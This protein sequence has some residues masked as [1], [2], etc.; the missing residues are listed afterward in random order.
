MAQ[1]Y[2]FTVEYPGVETK[3]SDKLYIIPQNYIT[4]FFFRYG[5]F[6]NND[7]S[8]IK[9]S[10]LDFR[11]AQN[12][13][14]KSK[15]EIDISIND[16]AFPE[17]ENFYLGRTFL[18][19]GYLYL[20]SKEDKNKFWE[21]K[22]S[23]NG[24][25]T[26]VVWGQE[27]DKDIKEVEA[28]GV[29]PCKI[30]VKPAEYY[31]A[32]SRTR[33]DKKYFRQLLSDENKL[34]ERAQL[35]NCNG[36][37]RTTV[38]SNSEVVN[39]NE[40]TFGYHKGRNYEKY[41]QDIQQAFA[42]C[43]NLD[44]P[45]PD[46][47]IDVYFDDMFIT[48]RDP[49]GCAEDIFEVLDEKTLHLKA[50]TASLPIGKSPESIKQDVKKREEEYED[51]NDNNDKNSRK[52]LTHVAIPTGIS[53]IFI[54]ALSVYQFVYGNT[55]NEKK[56]G[57]NVNKKMLE[58]ILAV[59]ERKNLREEIIN[60]R[61]DFVEFLD[62]YEYIR[63]FKDF[64][65]GNICNIVEG[66]LYCVKH[67]NLLAERFTN[68]DDHLFLRTEKFSKSSNIDNKR[69]RIRKF[70]E[71][72]Y[73]AEANFST[74]VVGI[75][76]LL[77]TLINLDDENLKNAIYATDLINKLA[78]LFDT[79]LDLYIKKPPLVNQKVS[80]L[81]RFIKSKIVDGE[82]FVKM[83]PNTI[84]NILKKY[85]I[86]ASEIDLGW[87]ESKNSYE[88][89]VQ[90]KRMSFVEEEIIGKKGKKY[91]IRR[92]KTDVEI[93]R[94][95][96]NLKNV[97]K[98][99]SNPYF[100]RALMKLSLLNLTVA[101]HQLDQDRSQNNMVN[102]AG[103]TADFA[104]ACTKSI[105]IQMGII[106]KSAKDIG[107]IGRFVK[108]INNFSS[109]A[110]SFLTAVYCGMESRDAFKV[111]D[112]D[113]GVAFAASGAFF[114][115][116][117]ILS[118]FTIPWGVGL[119]IGIFAIGSYI[120]ANY[121]RDDDFEN[122]FNNSWFRKLDGDKYEIFYKRIGEESWQYVSRIYSC[123]NLLMPDNDR[124][125]PWKEDI[126]KCFQDFLN[127]FNINNIE[128]RGTIY[129]VPNILIDFDVID[130]A[131]G[132]KVPP[133]YNNSKYADEIIIKTQFDFDRILSDPNQLEYQMYV[134]DKNYKPLKVEDFPKGSIRSNTVFVADDKK[135]LKTTIYIP[136]WL[137]ERHIE[138]NQLLIKLLFVCRLNLGDDY[139]PYTYVGEPI[140]LGVLVPLFILRHDFQ[141]M[142]DKTPYSHHFS[143]SDIS[144][145]V[146]TLKQ[147][148][149][150]AKQ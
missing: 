143:S 83:F 147:L 134:V 59:K 98:L 76:E 137:K 144:K 101:L 19:E 61:V 90:D 136:N 116:E 11:G 41:L 85:D 33:W 106:G 51:N 86:L 99:F 52:P 40:L 66:S 112:N 118:F 58:D 65:E 22:V 4:L 82:T 20:I 141:L 115:T 17:L 71:K 15:E 95:S 81:L 10:H 89:V 92:L 55:E 139:Y 69:E 111:G 34:K 75:P 14:T 146:G 114:T 121:W 132:K 1:E 142:S 148:K 119:L 77:N 36:I 54:N 27:N 49:F 24:L 122:Y 18:D 129:K 149:L 43:E 100:A 67:L 87:A 62:S 94:P 105:Q 48:L 102:V 107:K 150:W 60:Y 133:T 73:Y 131:T 45:A 109:K 7:S 138:K 39:Y 57:N 120:L 88:W 12:T 13:V 8:I 30:F 80:L 104:Y 128:V 113:A 46:A 130:E 96:K 93:K 5:Y 23:K 42:F 125:T 103:I 63:H 127:L 64:T 72:A 91:K 74:K 25:F 26:P 47:K 31:I 32:F 126:K 9:K 29:G 124:T 2:F 21:Y 6:F 70:L 68:I 38:S 135:T 50:L 123:R 117:M 56:Y 37:H 84:K 35:I 28:I 78:F 140:Y 79:T 53:T 44:D 3:K 108:N 16:K 97:E 110:S 145:N